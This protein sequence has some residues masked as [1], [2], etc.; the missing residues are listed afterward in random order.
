MAPLANVGL[1][2][3][4]FLGEKIAS[5]IF[6]HGSY[7]NQFQ[8]LKKFKEKYADGWEAK[9]LAYRKKTSLPITMIQI[10]LLISKKRPNS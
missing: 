1:S 3:Y 6:T 7:L 10:S 9:F 2:K 5:Q 4:S 8:G